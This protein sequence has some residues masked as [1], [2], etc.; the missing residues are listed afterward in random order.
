DALPAAPQTGATAPTPE[1]LGGHP[2]TLA[3]L[4][5]H[6]PGVEVT[7]LDPDAARLLLDFLRPLE[8]PVLFGRLEADPRPNLAKQLYGVS[9]P[10]LAAALLDVARKD[11]GR[12]VELIKPAGEG[13]YTVSLF[14]EA[15]PGSG[16]LRQIPIAVTDTILGPLRADMDGNQVLWPA[17]FDR[18]YAKLAALSLEQPIQL[19]DPL[20]TL[21]G[22]QVTMLD[23]T[24]DTQTLWQTLSLANAPLELPVTV[25][26]GNAGD[27]RGGTSEQAYS[28]LGTYVSQEGEP[29]V[30]LHGAQSGGYEAEAQLSVPLNTFKEALKQA[31][32]ADGRPELRIEGRQ[33]TEAPRGLGG[34]CMG[35][36]PRTVAAEGGRGAVSIRRLTENRCSLC[37][38]ARGMCLPTA[39]TSGPRGAR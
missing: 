32:A 19:H 8:K 37:P 3:A 38:V 10:S 36:M 35:S 7:S 23:A 18:A 24:A 22:R 2:D 27:G 17:L 16:R 12:L 4:S 20:T 11:P 28:V 15:P 1:L 26:A 31:V 30:I 5:Q 13:L 21:T 29:M 9:D 14:A 33:G 34:C 39:P 6:L 25:V